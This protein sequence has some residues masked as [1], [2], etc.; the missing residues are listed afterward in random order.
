MSCPAVITVNEHPPTGEYAAYVLHIIVRAGEDP[1]A[2][3]I[4]GHYDP[5]LTLDENLG[6][7]VQAYPD[8]ANAFRAVPSFLEWRREHW[9]EVAATQAP[10][11]RE[12]KEKKLVRL[13]LSSTARRTVERAP[14]I[15]T[16]AALE[17]L[18]NNNEERCLYETKNSYPLPEGGE[19]TVEE[20]YIIAG[21]TALL[22]QKELRYPETADY[23]VRSLRPVRRVPKE[24]RRAA[25]L[26]VMKERI[27]IVEAPSR[28]ERRGR[29]EELQ[30]ENA[31][32]TELLKQRERDNARLRQ[33]GNN[34][35][36]LDPHAIL[37]IPENASQSEI[38]RAYRHLATIYHPDLSR[39]PKSAEMFDL[40]DG[41]HR[42]LLGNKLA[43]S[44]RRHP[45][46]PQPQKPKT[47]VEQLLMQLA[48]STNEIRYCPTDNIVTITAKSPYC[49]AC[50][51]MKTTD[52]VKIAKIVRRGKATTPYCCT[53]MGLLILGDD[54][55]THYCEACG[56]PCLSTHALV[57]QS[58]DNG[59]MTFRLPPQTLASQPTRLR[60]SETELPP[61]LETPENIMDRAVKLAD[62]VTQWTKN[63][64]DQL[65]NLVGR[66]HVPTQAPY[67]AQCPRCGAVQAL[68]NSHI[69]YCHRCGAQLRLPF[70]PRYGHV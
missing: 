70:S 15:R 4:V 57:L 51:S 48:K 62:G 32:L 46:S 26:Q 3:D 55:T 42:E 44:D 63:L 43:S 47:I 2:Y 58:L 66:P 49:I 1:Q 60:R 6:R 37:G 64:A 27:H 52:H 40:I 9:P 8:L 36:P 35:L 12:E 11:G 69:R 67:V 53:K 17:S 34:V 23:F 18:V 13:T 30:R 59:T 7:L 41:A 68:T 28:R 16:V 29:E 19:E 56:E 31:R 22:L 45:S 33:D 38:K 21:D 25:A 65:D 61:P 5:L 10:P 14:N 24:I 54:E 39:N 20:S 50:R